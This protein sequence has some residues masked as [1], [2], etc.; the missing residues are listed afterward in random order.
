MKTTSKVTT[1]IHSKENTSQ[2]TCFFFSYAIVVRVK[3]RPGW[4]Q[5]FQHDD[6]DDKLEEDDNISGGIRDKRR[7]HKGARE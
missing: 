2:M 4:W 7:F 3:L 6:D 5:D 1:S